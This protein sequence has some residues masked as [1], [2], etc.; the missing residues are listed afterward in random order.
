MT[1]TQRWTCE[2][3]WPDATEHLQFAPGYALVSTAGRWLVVADQGHRDHHVI[4]YDH[5]PAPDPLN[6]IADDTDIDPA[7]HDRFTTWLDAANTGQWNLG[8]PVAAWH[9]VED[10][11]RA[12]YDPDEDG[13]LH[14][15]LFD[16]LGRQL[17]TTAATS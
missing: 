16:Q 4:T 14:L 6:D 5:Q 2:L 1:A 11:K 9:L 12:G 15:W 17:E 7:D 13:H 10:M 3:C 8:G